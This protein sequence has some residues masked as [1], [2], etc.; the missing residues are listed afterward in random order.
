MNGDLE[1]ILH[2]AAMALTRYYTGFLE[3]GLRKTTKTLVG[4]SGD[5]VEI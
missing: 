3:E 4:I 2:E 1:R 5:P